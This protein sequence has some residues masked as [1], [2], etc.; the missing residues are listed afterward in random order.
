MQNY[1]LITACAKTQK[2]IMLKRHYGASLRDWLGAAEYIMVEG[3]KK[4]NFMKEEYQHLTL[5]DRH[6]DLCWI[7]K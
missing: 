3:N 1:P 4:S 2:P 5:I 6:Q 7:Y